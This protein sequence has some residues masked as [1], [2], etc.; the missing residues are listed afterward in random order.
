LAD[1]KLQWYW[2]L[3][4][5]TPLGY[6]I[7]KEAGLRLAARFAKD[8]RDTNLPHVELE[9]QKYAMNKKMLL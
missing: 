4:F 2:N 7:A 5:I 3:S 6:G 1:L 9:R 8:M